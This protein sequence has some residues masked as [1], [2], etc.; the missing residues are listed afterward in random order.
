MSTSLWTLIRWRCCDLSARNQ[1]PQQHWKAAALPPEN[2]DAHGEKR[3]YLSCLGNGNQ[4]GG[5]N[6]SGWQQHG[7][8]VESV[9][10]YLRQLRTG[11][12]A[13]AKKYLSQRS[14]S[15]CP[16][17][18]RPP[19]N[20]ERSRPGNRAAVGKNKLVGAGAKING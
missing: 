13:H 16:A 18:A 11:Q 14:P 20:E 19:I 15:S 4:L 3:G 2:D 1:A 6:L 17:R 8:G 9:E 10:V 5:Y 7:A 12:A